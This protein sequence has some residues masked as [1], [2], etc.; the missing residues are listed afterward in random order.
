[1][2]A[3]ERKKLAGENVKASLQR[4]QHSM[5]MMSGAF[6]ILRG[7][8]ENVTAAHFDEWIERVSFILKEMKTLRAG[9]SDGRAASRRA[10]KKVGA[11]K[12]PRSTKR[13]V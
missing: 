3:I 5:N 2:L 13:R 9:S 6:T 8:P 4:W 10:V 12:S 1:M 11:S 7:K